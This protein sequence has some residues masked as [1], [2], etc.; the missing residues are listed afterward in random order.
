MTS[1][2]YNA[3]STM[4]RKKHAVKSNAALRK[5]MVLS[6]LHAESVAQIVLIRS[7]FKLEKEYT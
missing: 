6:S 1:H 3:L 5:C 4:R 2:E 7:A